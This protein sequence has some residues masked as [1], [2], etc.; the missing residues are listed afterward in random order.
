M[1]E[2]FTLT[3]DEW[4]RLGGTLPPDGY[5]PDVRRSAAVQPRGIAARQQHT[6]G[7]VPAIQY[8][9]AAIWQEVS[10]RLGI[11]MLSIRWPDPF[12]PD[13]LAERNPK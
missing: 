1:R 8:D 6:R 3:D 2:S 10:E 9:T 11:R 13:F 12:Y 7:T 4:R 5:E